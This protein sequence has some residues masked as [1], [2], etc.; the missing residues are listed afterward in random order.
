MNGFE[1]FVRLK[2]CWSG[3]KR[4]YKLEKYE[5]INGD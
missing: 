5:R 2:K 3:G 4:I 1:F